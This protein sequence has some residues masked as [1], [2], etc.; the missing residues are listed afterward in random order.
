ML[1]TAEVM[2]VST[3][4]FQRVLRAFVAA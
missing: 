3:R 4:L 2:L 1:E